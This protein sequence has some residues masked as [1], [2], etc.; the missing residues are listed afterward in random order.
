[1]QPRL[2]FRYLWIVLIASFLA[3]FVWAMVQNLTRTEQTREQ[4]S[5]PISSKD[6]S[7]AKIEIGNFEQIEG[8]NIQRS[9]IYLADETQDKFSSSGYSRSVLNYTFFD[10]TQKIFYLLKPDNE[11]RLIS[12]VELAESANSKLDTKKNVPVAFSY[13]IIDQDTNKDQQI[14]Q[15][16]LKKLAISDTSGLRFKVLIDQVDNFNGASIVKNNRVFLF[17]LSVNK[18]KAAE[19]DL[20]SQEIVSTTELKP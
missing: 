6:G 5:I 4:A 17:Y 2:N 19:V 12:T 9:P 11:S 7:Q 14:N 8:T 20:R 16:D 1:M 10:S 13:L 15:L 18:L 3:W